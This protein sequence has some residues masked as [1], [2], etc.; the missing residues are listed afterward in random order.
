MSQFDG[1]IFQAGKSYSVPDALIK[2]IIRAE[3]NFD[4]R[5]KR[6]EANVG[7]YSYGL[8]QVRCDTAK[9][10]GWNG[11]CGDLLNPETNIQVGTKF[12]AYLQAQFPNDIERVISA[13]NAGPG[14]AERP[15]VNPGYVNKVLGFLR[16][17]NFVIEDEKNSVVT[18]R[19]GTPQMGPV[20]YSPGS[21]LSPVRVSVERDETGLAVTGEA[22]LKDE[23]VPWVLGGA[24]VLAYMLMG[25]SNRWRG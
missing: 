6:H 21:P 7:D 24:A 22:I 14:N 13:Y 19:P 1:L 25:P 15:F 23:H 17:Y 11:N 20:P 18:L 16:G 5:A 12:L 2:A 8:M 9:W 4:P 3:S 10:M